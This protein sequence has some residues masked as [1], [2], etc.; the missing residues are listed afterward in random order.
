MKTKLSEILSDQ[1][2]RDADFDIEIKAESDIEVM[3]WQTLLSKEPETI[4]WIKGF[5]RDSVFIDIGANIGVYTLVSCF[6]PVSRVIAFE[7]FSANY[8]KLMDNILSNNL[9]NVFAFNCGIGGYPKVVELKGESFSPGAAEFSYSSDLENNTAVAT[10]L[11]FNIFE[12]LIKR[13][14]VDLFI[15][16][17]VD[18]GEMGV[19]QSLES[20]LNHERN[21]SV[22]VE[23]DVDNE[24]AVEYFMSERKFRLDLYFELF[25]PHSITRRLQEAGNRARNHVY[26][27][28]SAH[29]ACQR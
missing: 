10:L 7:P 23:A 26:S 18:G 3:R 22:L 27:N 15:K 6:T 2:A 25:R 19:L 13:T 16:I 21:I 12:P 17:D 29:A 9:E 24:S 11:P 28:K 20:V 8:T 4:E 1:F 14:S 5:T